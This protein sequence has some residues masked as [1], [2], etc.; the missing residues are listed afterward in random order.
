MPGMMNRFASDV[1]AR[2]PHVA[3]LPRRPSTASASLLQE[4][5]LYL[6]AGVVGFEP[7]FA[8][9]RVISRRESKITWAFGRATRMKGWRP[10]P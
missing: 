3:I 9:W 10:P 5:S 6:K 7:E 2:L 8:M 1:T 4:G